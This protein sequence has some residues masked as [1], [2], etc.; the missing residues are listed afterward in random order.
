MNVGRLTTDER[1]LVV[2]EIGN[3][4]EGD[5]GAACELVDRAAESGVD[6]V[7]VQTFQVK[8]FVSA[9]D[10][11]RYQRLSRFALSYDQFAELSARARSRGLLFIATPLDLDSAAFLDGVVDAFK[12]A[13][14]DNNF[15]ALIERV[16]D[17]GKPVILSSG[18]SDLAVIR[19]GVRIVR[20]QW[21]ARSLTENLAVLHCVSSYP[22]PDD[23]ANLR[24]IPLLARELGCT[25]GYSDHTLGIAASL[26][27]VAL[28][29]RII[30]KHFTLDKQR[31]DF[32][33]HQL[34]ADPRE[35]T[36]LVQQTRRIAAMLGAGEKVA[37][38]SEAAAEQLSRR[39]IVASA[40][41]PRGH[42]LGPQDFTWIRPGTGLAPGEEHRLVGRQLKRDVAFGE[43]ILV[44]DVE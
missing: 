10:Q 2:A 34:S 26:A 41:F 23:E 24:A 5:F 15:V 40:A 20:E 32:R 19:R 43:P 44:A 38:P 31:S 17:T 3:N 29:A 13:S 14:G 21:Q 22:V 16:A 9:A 18:F 12:I 37:Q 42:K 1:V 30:E 27:A 25:V 36:E 28:G 35:M 8:Y 4:H 39:S 33:D 11:A 7:K 6:A